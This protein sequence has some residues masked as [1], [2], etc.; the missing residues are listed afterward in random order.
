[1]ITNESQKLAF[2]AG[3]NTALKGAIPNIKKGHPLYK[4]FM[5]GF[6]EASRFQIRPQRIFNMTPAKYRHCC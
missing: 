6:K 1:M 4:D 3:Y 2:D 5:A